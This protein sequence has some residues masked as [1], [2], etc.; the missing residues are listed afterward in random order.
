MPNHGYLIKGQGISF[1]GDSRPRN[2]QPVHHTVHSL[3]SLKW[4]VAVIW[5]WMN[6]ES[7][8]WSEICISFLYKN[9]ILKD[10]R[11]HPYFSTI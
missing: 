2:P 4:A 5:R 8:I 1:K 3:K 9:P 7:L 6:N 10:S 11:T